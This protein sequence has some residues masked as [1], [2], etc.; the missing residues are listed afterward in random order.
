MTFLNLLVIFLL[1][2]HQAIFRLA[3]SS[4]E[5]E[6]THDY[7]TYKGPKGSAVRLDNGTEVVLY[8][9]VQESKPWMVQEGGGGGGERWRRRRWLSSAFGVCSLCK[10]CD[11]TQTVCSLVGCCF[12]IVCNA[13]NEPFGL[14]SLSPSACNCLS[15]PASP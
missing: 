12:S 7:I 2:F 1:L 10:C 6:D 14:C 4:P 13:P 15:C 9:V 5:K 8:P 3:F 11:S